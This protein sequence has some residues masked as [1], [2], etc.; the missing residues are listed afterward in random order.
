MSDYLIASYA[1]KGSRYVESLNKQ[2]ALFG[3]RHRGYIFDDQGSWAANTKMKWHAIKRAFNSGADR[4]VWVDSD[5]SINPPDSWPDVE[6][7]VGIIDNVHPDHK[8]RISAGFILFR[9]TDKCD[10]FLQEWDKNCRSSTTDH[11]ALTK[12]I[13]E[14]VH[15]AKI[16]NVSWWLEGRH[17][18]NALLPDRGEFEG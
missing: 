9:N 6:F 18:I 2:S 4:V 1:T 15:S 7:D 12:T 11:N 13:V 16:E 10:L 5:C 3:Y 8:N 14:N 17:T